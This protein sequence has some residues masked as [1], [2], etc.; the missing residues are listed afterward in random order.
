MSEN[1]NVFHDVYCLNFGKSKALKIKKRFSDQEEKQ[2]N[3]MNILII[4]FPLLFVAMRIKSDL[5]RQNKDLL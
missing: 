2:S 1:E 3:R 4:V 5:K